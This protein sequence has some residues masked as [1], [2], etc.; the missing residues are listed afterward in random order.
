MSSVIPEILSRATLNDYDEFVPGAII[1]LINLDQES[2]SKLELI[3]SIC[4]VLTPQSIL[5][6][7]RGK[8]RKCLLNHMRKSELNELLSHLGHE[9]EEDPWEF[10]I[11]LKFSNELENKLLKYFNLERPIFETENDTVI[12]PQ[13][14]AIETNYG[15]FRHQL[16]AIQR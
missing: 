1:D 10:A 12:E 13:K 6:E 11:N 14:E 3:T 15:L 16:D 9:I 7:T 4:D 5:L 8:G 2:P